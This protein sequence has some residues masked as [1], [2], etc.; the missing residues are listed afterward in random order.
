[1]INCTGPRR[2][3]RRS[4]VPLIADLQTRGLATADALGLGLE[5]EDAALVNARGKPSDRL[6]AL[7]ALTCPSWWEITAVPEIAIQVDRLAARLARAEGKGPSNTPPA[8]T[9]F[10][11]L[12]AGI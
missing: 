11:N 4:G 8:A 12:G 10:L 7:G 2:D 9:D 3:L 5:T 1:V 6:F